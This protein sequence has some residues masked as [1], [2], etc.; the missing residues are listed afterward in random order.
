MISVVRTALLLFGLAAILFGEQVPKVPWTIVPREIAS[1]AGGDSAQPQMTVSNRGVLLSW[2][3]RVDGAP[4]LRFAER[5]GNGWTAARSVA[6]GS[7]WFVNW[8]DVPSVARLDDRTIAAHW[9]Q[10]SGASTYAYDVRLTHSTDAGQTWTPAVV[11]HTDGTKTEHGFASL[12]PLA[13]VN[14]GLGLV[15]LD[16]RAMTN[17]HGGHGGGDMSLRFGAFDRQWRQVAETSIDDRVCECCPTAAAITADGPVVAYRNRGP[18][19]S[20]DI[21]IARF[22]NGKWTTGVATSQ[23]SWR[24]NAC[25]VNGPSLSAR[26]GTVVLGWF[27][28]RNDQP[29]AFAAF[30][31]DAGRTFGAPIRL[32]D[33]ASHG[34]VDV[35]LLPDGSAAALYVEYG[36]RKPRV[37]VR[38]IEAS[39]SRSQPITIAAI[40]DGRAGGYPRM[41]RHGNEL[42]FAWLE[43]AGSPRVKTAAAL[44]DR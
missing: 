44:L 27:T 33:G 10:K 5:S 2:I 13:G 7:D 28:A 16:G 30:S 34:R 43:R 31:R 37:N 32:D 15:W 42:V 9:L 26:G 8:A 20:R 41:A 17:G 39:G 21:H 12:F 18:D 22:Q 4:T 25:P 1:P 6:S 35:D 23:D 24:I 11:P 19:E 38:R 3:E 14:G 29:Q 36:D 40:E